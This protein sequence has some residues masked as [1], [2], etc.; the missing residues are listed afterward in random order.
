M[1]A[2]YG[3]RA[4]DGGRQGERGALRKNSHRAGHGNV[5]KQ[6]RCGL[7]AG[8]HQDYQDGKKADTGDKHDGDTAKD[9]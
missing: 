5:Q 1:P 6:R 8:S 4:A 2:T 7:C 3:G 9:A